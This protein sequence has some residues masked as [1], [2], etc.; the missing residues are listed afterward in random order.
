MTLTRYRHTIAL[1]L[2]GGCGIAN[3]GLVVIRKIRY[4]TNS[5]IWCHT[6][7]L[8]AS[9]IDDV[10][11]TRTVRGP[12]EFTA[13]LTSI[14]VVLIAIVA[15]LARR[16]I[17]QPIATVRHRAIGVAGSRRARIIARLTGGSVDHT[18]AAPRDRTVCV[19]NGRRARIIARLTGCSVHDA[20]T[21]ARDR[22]V[23]V[24]FGRRARI[25]APLTGG[26][27]HDA[28]TAA[29][30]RTVCV[31]C[32][33]RAGIITRFAR[34][35]VGD[36]ITAERS[37]T[38]CLSTIGRADLAALQAIAAYFREGIAVIAGFAVESIEG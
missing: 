19:A 2:A 1:K 16:A 22:T 20:I 17:D 12:S 29:R 10:L 4:A 24:A 36:S 3:I 34:I 37:R 11:P 8:T 6:T 15:N 35:R 5:G 21:A 26:G 30:D 9:H 27:V 32:G 28:I 13:L 23:C 31:A 14:A 7:D 38:R 33:R 18:I 25:I